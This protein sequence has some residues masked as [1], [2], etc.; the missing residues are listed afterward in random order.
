MIMGERI[1]T[2]FTSLTLDMVLLNGV[3][4]DMSLGQNNTTLIASRED[5]PGFTDSDTQRHKDRPWAT[6]LLGGHFERRTGIMNFSGTYVNQHRTNSLVPWSENSLSGVLPSDMSPVG[7][8]VVKIS[9]GSNKHEGGARVFD[10]R[11]DGEFRDIIP[12][13]TRH[14]SKLRSRESF[15]RN[16][17]G[18]FRFGQIP[19]FVEFIETPEVLQ[20]EHPVQGQFLEADGDE[21]LLYWF[22]IPPERRDRMRS[23]HFRALLANDY[24]ISLSEIYVN[25]N[26]SEA[27]RKKLGQAI[28]FHRATNFYDVAWAKGSVEDMSNLGWVTFSYGRQ[29]GRML[30]GLRLDIESKGFQMR[31]ELVSSFNFLQFPADNGLGER[32]RE[33]T[34]AFFI[35][36]KKNFER[37]SVGGEYFNIAPNYSTIL[38]IEDKTY[39]S[40]ATGINDPFFGRVPGGEEKRLNNTFDFSTIDDND[41][42]DRFPDIHHLE[43]DF[44]DQN[45]VFPGLDRDLNGRP[46]TNENNNEFPDYVEPFLLYKVDPQ[47]YDYGNDLNNNGIIDNREDDNKPDYPYNLDQKGYHLFTEI[48]PALGAQLTVGRYDMKEIAGAGRN[49]VT[50]T[51]ITYD[52]GFYPFGRI[53]L[54]DL[55]KRVEDDISDDVFVFVPFV[56]GAL[57]LTNEVREFGIGSAYDG[58]VRDNVQLVEDPLLMKNSIVNT[59]FLDATFFGIPD[60]TI[61]NHLKSITNVQRKSKDQESNKIQEWAWVLRGNYFLRQGKLTIT[62][63]VKYMQYRKNDRESRYQK[64]SERF[65]YPILMVDYRLTENTTVRFGAQGLPFLKSRFWNGLNSQLDYES[66]DDIV[67]VSSSSKYKGY[68]LTLNV[69]Y[70]LQRLEYKSR[71]HHFDDVDRSLFFIRLVMGLQPFKG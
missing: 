29:T 48:K 42:R 50:Y 26:P 49:L 69:G 3:R 19:P 54:T 14:N 66:Q 52:R 47:E 23:A 11:M 38:S 61:N 27:D 56:S 16:Q 55:L 34:N 40:Y 63:R 8:L 32:N 4:W 15:E 71:R 5:W 30:G 7:Y 64:V 68:I 25:G 10:V 22:E 12:V 36:A 21:Y 37:F 18:A 67:M 44:Q 20:T 28:L 6:Y 13:V 65:F 43:M 1:R 24:R 33:T 53:E 39:Q 31:S 41:D 2:K 70:Q 62:P 57:P 60:L 45:G 17:D 51:E 9:D 58:A 35:N 46:D 59:A